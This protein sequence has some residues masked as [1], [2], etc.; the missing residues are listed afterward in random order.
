MEGRIREFPGIWKSNDQSI[1][2]LMMK[3]PFFCCFSAQ[4]PMYTG[5][6]GA[7]CVYVS[8][9]VVDPRVSSKLSF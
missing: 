4:N 9:I 1:P 7:S 6:N 2:Y 8:C 5:C 3:A